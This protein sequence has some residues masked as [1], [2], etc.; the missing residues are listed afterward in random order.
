MAKTAMCDDCSAIINEGDGYIFYSTAGSGFAGV[1]LETGN[2]LLCQKC[3]DR[4][5]SPEGFAKK[6]PA[7]QELSGGI[8]VDPGE[9]SRM[10]RDANL[11]SIVQRCKAH[12][13]TPEQAKAKAHEFA[14]LWW[15]NREKAQLDSAAFWKSG[16]QTSDSGCFVATACYGSPECLE[17][18]ELRRFRDD[19]LL[20]G[21][22][23]RRIVALYYRL[24]PPIARFLEGNAVAR[25][26][27]RNLF[28]A[29]VYRIVKRK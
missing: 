1:V 9:Y 12:G 2:M 21:T 13:F 24:S 11:V 15:T 17:V 4:I 29:P 25:A 18:A 14:L 5:C 26:L 23:G 10:M 8:L 20:P 7:S 6:I 27:V 19:V 22:L 28:V 3:T 16:K